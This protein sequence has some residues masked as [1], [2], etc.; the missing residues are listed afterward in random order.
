[1]ALPLLAAAACSSTVTGSGSKEGGEGGE[2]GQ[3]GQSSGGS[4]GG[5]GQS[6]GGQS[7]GG[8]DGG[9]GQSSGGQ[10]SGGQSSGGSDGSGGQSSGNLS[11]TEGTLQVG[12]PTEFDT[13]S[14]DDSYT[15]ECG[16]GSS[17]DA[18]FV[19]TA[20]STNFYAFDSG[21]SG[22]DTVV[23][24]L[25]GDCDGAEL[26][27][28][29]ANGA[30]PQ[31]RAITKV[32][33]DQRVVVVLDGN[34]GE[35]GD[36]TLSVTPI[37]C[38]STDVSDQPLPATLTT[39]GGTNTH[40]GECGGADSPEKAIRY[41][42]KSAG[43][44][45]FSV[46]SEDFSPALYVEQGPECGGRLL[47]CNANLAGGHP[48]EVTRWLDQGDAVTLIVDGGA[49][50][51]TLDAEKLED[52]GSCPTLPTLDGATDVV[53]D[54]TSPNVFSPSCEW[55]GN[56]SLDDT[57]NSYRDHAYTF[58]VDLGPAGNCMVSVVGSDANML[59][60]LL[61]GDRCE[62]PELQCEGPVIS[63]S[64]SF[65]HANNGVYTLVI[66]NAHPFNGSLTYSIS[67]SC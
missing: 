40:D 64:F 20:P 53:I 26:A 28:S 58:T 7:S 18:A 42:A 17:P 61:E 57:S 31:A 35:S 59:V 6:S 34:L 38:P 55:A 19:W 25:D 43:L 23:T 1:L 22:F 32:Q 60:Y 37:T 3:G 48:A 5:G 56:T 4:D 66:E 12:T 15:T 51:F 11:C 63:H 16:D 39:V 67:T 41:V 36:A 65:A 2:G 21:G 24:V 54:D 47:Q 33:K 8:S 27:C 44:Y 10:S 46:A 50:T 14:Q 13:S 45:R 9:G 49:G 29:N 62:G 30:S 52:P